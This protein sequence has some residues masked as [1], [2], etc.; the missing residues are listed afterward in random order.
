MRYLDDYSVSEVAEILGC[1]YASAESLL[2]RGRRG[3]AIALE[4]R[5]P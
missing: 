3:L 2:A 1:S 4:E 5:S